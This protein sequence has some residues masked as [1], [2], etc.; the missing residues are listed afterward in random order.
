M[1]LLVKK[2]FE[3]F[4]V[5]VKILWREQISFGHPQQ[6]VGKSQEV[7]G[8]GRLIFFVKGKNRRRG[9]DFTSPRSLWSVASFPI[10]SLNFP[11]LGV[12]SRN[13]IKEYKCPA[14]CS[15]RILK[16]I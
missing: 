5:V 1:A 4:V 13:N 16:S 9:M 3:N 11:I 14:P 6:K 2:F 15:L 12:V 7:S 10:L 8:M